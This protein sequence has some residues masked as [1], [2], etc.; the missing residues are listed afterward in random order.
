MSREGNREFVFEKD[1]KIQENF[2]SGFSRK[3]CHATRTC[4]GGYVS[5]SFFPY[6]QGVL[7]PGDWPQEEDINNPV[8]F[9]D[10]ARQKLYGELV[11]RPVNFDARQTA[12]FCIE[13]LITLTWQVYLPG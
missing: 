13:G 8:Q 9:G 10:E 7:I 4:R 2:P 6:H 1:D 12:N 3:A 11:A 5:Y